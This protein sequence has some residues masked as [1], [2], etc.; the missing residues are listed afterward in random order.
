MVFIIWFK[1]R[2][3][4]GQNGD[5]IGDC[6]DF[7]V[8]PIQKVMARPYGPARILILEHDIPE[9][10]GESRRNVHYNDGLVF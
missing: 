2:L 4:R 9:R 10:E 8:P 5:I 6:A 3:V 1:I 7:R